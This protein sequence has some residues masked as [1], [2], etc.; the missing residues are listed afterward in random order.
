MRQVT[1]RLGSLARWTVGAILL[2][3]CGGNDDRYL[4]EPAEAA[5]GHT[6]ASTDT[7]AGSSGRPTSSGGA[8]HAG[9]TQTALSDAEGQGGD[10]NIGGTAGSTT[11]E[12]SQSTD[13]SA[14]GLEGGTTF[15]GALGS[16]GAPLG[17]AGA[18]G[19]SGATNGGTS[20]P[21][22]GTGGTVAG[23]T[24]AGGSSCKE[25][26]DCTKFEDGNRCNGTLRCVIG[27]CEIDPATIITC[28]A[29]RDSV[30]G[31][32]T[33]NASL[34]T[35]AMVPLL[36]NGR[37]CDDADACTVTDVCLDGLCRGTPVTPGVPTPKWPNNGSYS[38]S[39]HAGSLSLRPE[40]VWSRASEAC[41][42]TSFD[43]V[44]D[45]S[46][47]LTEFAGCPMSSPEASASAVLLE[48]WQPSV[49][50]P[51]STL[52]P[53]GR[54][55]YWRVRGCRQSSC[56]AWS[57]IRYLEV[58]RVPSDFNGDGYSDVAVSN[59]RAWWGSGSVGAVFVYYGSSSGIS[60]TPSSAALLTGD[61]SYGLGI[62]SPDLNGDG[63]SELL[64]GNGT[65][66]ALGARLFIGHST[67]I[68]KT[69]TR[70]RTLNI[71]G[72]RLAD[73]GDLDGDGLTELASAFQIW[74]D[75]SGRGNVQILK[76]SISDYAANQT[77]S[78]TLPFPA[79]CDTTTGELC[80]FGLDLNSAGDVNSD[81]L[82]DLLVGAPYAGPTGSRHG[83]AFLYLG[84]D[85]NFGAVADAV[86]QS[87]TLTQFG[88]NARGIGDYNGDRVSDWAVRS[89]YKPAGSVYYGPLLN[90]APAADASLPETTSGSTYGARFLT[91]LP[92]ANGGAAVVTAANV[93]V[94]IQTSTATVRIANPDA[95]LY[96][97][98]GWHV[99]SVGDVNGDGRTDLGVGLHLKGASLH[100]T[101]A[102]MILLGQAEA[103]WLAPSTRLMPATDTTYPMFGANITDVRW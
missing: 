52:Q 27:G 76:G 8:G 91:S 40:L 75:G 56:S 69:H 2:C 95:T 54:R 44:V 3:A 10:G 33:C 97:G 73:A 7:T 13:T 32:N 103:P 16:A 98:F 64:V 93:E 58:G 17:L 102:V 99:A 21:T 72:V 78:L 71:P 60:D 62:A 53:V 23:G 89:R 55:Y 61:P 45:D 38:G 57:K 94:V 86:F 47:T 67:G 81:G 34:G 30:C 11:T 12:S 43:V 31:K 63:Y 66:D 101:N 24:S 90:A 82:V 92:L 80:E 46:C 35:C 100:E 96:D 79:T 39:L 50:L 84:R 65:E 74:F 5:A 48:H 42:A 51:V 25:N 4:W 22:A 70:N 85:V 18:G 26:N 29:G 41:P 36:P 14:N 83:Q 68:E 9:R 49:N 88:A 87:D 6:S 1:N 59:A 77:A 15:G 19:V 37:D 20:S 28:D